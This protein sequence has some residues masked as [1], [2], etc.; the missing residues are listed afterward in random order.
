MESTQ[1]F[2][3]TRIEPRD[4]GLFFGR[5]EI[6]AAKAVAEDDEYAERVAIGVIIRSPATATLADLQATIV[7][8]AV[9]RLSLALKMVEGRTAQDLL[10]TA[11]RVH[12]KMP[13]AAPG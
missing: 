10:A 8:A 4:D 5:V 6:V 7:D 2:A 11:T 3:I 9:S 13:L 1:S 12:L